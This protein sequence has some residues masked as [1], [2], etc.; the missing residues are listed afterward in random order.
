MSALQEAARTY[1]GIARLRK[2]P[3]DVPAVPSLL[4][5]TLVAYAIVSLGFGA[6]LPA[7]DANPVALFAIDTVLMLAWIK[8]LLQLA[9]HPERFLQTTL[10]V[11][12]V[13]LVLA[14]LF[15]VGMAA[16]LRFNQDPTWQLP[17]S[18][19][20]LALGVWAL[21]VNTRILQ[22]ATQWPALACSA[23]VIVQSV[24]VNLI[25]IAVFPGASADANPLTPA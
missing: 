6:L 4:G 23:L 16:Y 14:P 24:V 10:A 3:E 21:V 5:A 25:L 2:G 17:V 19:L 15:A 7:R 1:V 9:R 8:L 13:Q 12:G 22:A 18:M 11:F 20:V